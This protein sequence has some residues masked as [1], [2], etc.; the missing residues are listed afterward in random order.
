[1]AIRSAD[2]TGS[3]VHPALRGRVN[4][5]ARSDLFSNDFATKFIRLT[6]ERRGQREQKENTNL[7]L[8]VSAI[9][10]ERSTQTR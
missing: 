5:P 2:D 6:G 1:M 7:V 4:L 10:T 3:V 8:R 9:T